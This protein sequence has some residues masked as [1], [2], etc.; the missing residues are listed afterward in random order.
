MKI[1]RTSSITFYHRP[2]IFNLSPTKQR[3][4]SPDNQP[5]LSK[6]NQMSISQLST[7]TDRDVLTH[8]DIN[9]DPRL[10]IQFSLSFRL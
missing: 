4:H 8:I 2:I 9:P 3:K 7:R 10:I 6:K 1:E 5:K